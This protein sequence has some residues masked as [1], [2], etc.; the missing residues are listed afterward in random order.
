MEDSERR[1]AL[2]TAIS[3]RLRP[4]CS[5][6]PEDLFSAMVERLTEITMKYEGRGA[7]MY[8]RRSTEMLVNEL[9]AVLERSENSRDS[10]SGRNATGLVSLLLPITMELLHNLPT[11]IT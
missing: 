6:W 5:D 2:A 11:R 8:D 10:G 9:K 7:A 1:A 4:L 3:A